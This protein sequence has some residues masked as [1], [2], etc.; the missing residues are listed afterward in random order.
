MNLD[1]G[2]DMSAAVEY[3]R[4][5]DQL[6]PLQVDVDDVYPTE[7]LDALRSRGHNV[8]GKLCANSRI[9]PP[10]TLAQSWT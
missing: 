1:W 8:T 5:Q 7:L 4:M 2:L 10:L 3:G 9:D 6:Y